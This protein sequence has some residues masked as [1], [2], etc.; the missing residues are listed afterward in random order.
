MKLASS[1]IL[2]SG[3]ST[4]I[5]WYRELIEGAGGSVPHDTT[6][7]GGT[8]LRVSRAE[9]QRLANGYLIQVSP[10]GDDRPL[11]R[12]RI[13][14]LSVHGA[15]KAGLAVG[16][17]LFRGC[18]GL[19]EQVRAVA[20]SGDGIRFIGAASGWMTYNTTALGCIAGWNGGYGIA[21]DDR[22]SADQ[23]LVHCIVNNNGRGGLY[24]GGASHQATGLHAYANQGYG[25]RL[26]RFNANSKLVNCKLEHNAGGGLSIDAGASGTQIGTCGF[27]GNRV[28]AICI[29]GSGDLIV[30]G[31]RFDPH[32]D[33]GAAHGVYALDFAA[34]PAALIDGNLALPGWTSGEAIHFQSSHDNVVFGT[35]I[36]LER[37]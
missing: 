20:L 6:Y 27:R 37:P 36:G 31:C 5:N 26:G 24:L 19:V 34:N 29:A 22:Q 1:R 21:L 33:K 23:H 15:G 14:H 11:A 28:S 10:T 4:A 7:G 3:F 32:V 9:N 30:Q 25:V 2:T 17:I 8:T 18:D 13:A 35:N 16:G 12:V